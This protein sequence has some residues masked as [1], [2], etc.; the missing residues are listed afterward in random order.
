MAKELFVQTGLW[1]QAAVLRKIKEHSGLG[2]QKIADIIGVTKRMIFHYLK[3]NC[4]I[5]LSNLKTLC[6]ETGFDLK[7]IE[8]LQLIELDQFG[9]KE[10]RKPKLGKE[11]AEFLGAMSGDGNI[12]EKNYRVSITCGAIV[13]NAYVKN[14]IGKKFEK[15][16]GLEPTF[17]VKNG[18]IRCQVY[19]KRLVSY[20]SE[21]FGFPKGNRKNRMFIQRKILNDRNLLAAYLRGLFDTDGSFHRRRKNSAVVEFISCS[22]NFLYEVKCALVSLGFKASLSGKS[23][24]IYDQAHVDTFFKLIKPSNI[25]HS[26]KYRIFKETGIVPT[27]ADFLKAAVV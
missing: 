25:K 19:S 9:E 24:Y 21:E 18:A 14:S 17:I 15:L 4:R 12:Y 11:L 10:I 1:H 20:L 5:S 7:E 26:I 8:K 3:E 6:K 13:D 2:W 27:H 22:P 16:F 23:V